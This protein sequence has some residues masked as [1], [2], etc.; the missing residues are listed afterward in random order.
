[1]SK[2]IKL[3]QGRSQ[4]KCLGWANC[5]KKKKKI[6]GWTKLLNLEDLLEF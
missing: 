6:L 5:K 2:N 4:R 3:E 1:M